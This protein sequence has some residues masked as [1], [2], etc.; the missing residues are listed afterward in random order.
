MSKVIV[1]RARLSQPEL[2][3][4]PSRSPFPFS[5]QIWQVCLCWQLFHIC[6]TEVSLCSRVC[7]ICVICKSM[8]WRKAS[9][10]SKIKI[11]FE[12]L[13]ITMSYS[14]LPLIIT[15]LEWKTL[16]GC[17]FR[18]FLA[19]AW[20]ETHW[21]LPDSTAV[22]RK[23]QVLNEVYSKDAG[24]MPSMPSHVNFFTTYWWN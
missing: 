17:N 16:M 15:A 8:N 11:S 22:V 23:E 2:Q 10:F 13:N 19:P 24:R 18:Q 14:F 4:G 20:P 7:G 1:S 9:S 5:W 21:F 12:L 6:C 3:P